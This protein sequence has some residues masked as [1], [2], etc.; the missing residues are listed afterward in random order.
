MGKLGDVDFSDG[1][2]ASLRWLSQ[3]LTYEGLLDG[4]PTDQLNR[5]LIAS[6]RERY[7]HVGP[8]QDPHEPLVIESGQLQLP[9]REH[10]PFGQRSILP[11]VF[12]AAEY[13]SPTPVPAEQ[14]WTES[15]LVLVWWQDDWG[16][17]QQVLREDEDR[18]Q[19]VAALYKAFHPYARISRVPLRLPDR[20]V[21]RIDGLRGRQTRGSYVRWVLEQVLEEEVTT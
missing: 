3:S 12:C 14:T 6:A 2:R 20:T 10:D 13:W 18:D 16:V 17:V 9:V 1:V 21:A 11:R 19:R 15:Y 4:A 5:D 8:G 7:R